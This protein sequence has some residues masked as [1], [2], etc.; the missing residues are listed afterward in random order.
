M[1]QGKII[2]FLLY[3][4][5][6]LFKFIAGDERLLSIILF[7]T[8]LTLPHRLWQSNQKEKVLHLAQ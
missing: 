8:G 6:E 7:Q 4:Q 1:Y 3:V 2:E 5:T